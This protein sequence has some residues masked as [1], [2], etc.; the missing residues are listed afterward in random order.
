VARPSRPYTGV[1]WLPR[2][3]TGRRTAAGRV[4]LR[5]QPVRELEARRRAPRTFP[6][7]V[8]SVQI[9]LNLDDAPGVSEWW[10][11]LEVA[12]GAQVRLR[13]SPELSFVVDGKNHE[14][15]L[16]KPWK[17]ASTPWRPGAEPL[18]VRIV[19]DHTAVD[20]FALGGSFATSAVTNG[21]A[22]DGNLQIE[23]TGHA[24]LLTACGWRLV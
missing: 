19:L 23:A 20:V 17:P 12:D 6:A 21:T 4:D 11:T 18:E 15:R 1:I 5:Y 7:Q 13:F 24:Q 3:L 8:L 16:E 2:E 22:C 10:L 14:L 9:A